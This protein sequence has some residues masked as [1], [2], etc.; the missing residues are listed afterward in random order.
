MSDILILGLGNEIVADDRFGYAV[1]DEL[2]AHVPDGGIV[3][4]V[5]APLAGFGLLDFLKDRYAA[6]IVDAIMT[7][8]SSPG[9]LYFFTSGHLTPTRHLCGSH[10]ISLP[11]ALELGRKM[12]YDM[13]KRIDVLAAEAEDITTITESMTPAVESAVAKAVDQVLAWINEV[14][15]EVNNVNKIAAIG[16]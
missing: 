12:G 8:N 6:L 2:S 5:F 1:I 14:S 15:A 9:T 10:Q 16:S 7:G 3:E 4:A 13:P 11:A